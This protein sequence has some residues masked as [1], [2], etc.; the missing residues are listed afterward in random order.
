MK[1][2]A[3]ATYLGHHWGDVG[4]SV[5]SIECQQLTLLHSIVLCSCPFLISSLRQVSGCHIHWSS[6]NILVASFPFQILHSVLG[7]LI[8]KM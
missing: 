6:I 2:D 7:F 5:E 1:E 4:S 8:Y 3:G